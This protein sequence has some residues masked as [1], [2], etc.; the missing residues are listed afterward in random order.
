MAVLVTLNEVKDQLSIEDGSRDTLLL[1][2]ADVASRLVYNY[3]TD[4]NKTTWTDRTV[5]STVKAATLIVAANLFA[6]RGDAIPADNTVLPQLA[7]DLLF[8]YHDPSFA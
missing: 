5:P 4:T 1:R 8:N 7:R 6:N 3:V 2:I